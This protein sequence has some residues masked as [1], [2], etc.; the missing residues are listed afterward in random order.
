MAGPEQRGKRGIQGCG[1][2][3]AGLFRQGLA[4]ILEALD[5]QIDRFFKIPQLGGT[6]GQL[7]RELPL[8]LQGFDGLPGS[9][10]VALA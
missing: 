3:I 5:L 7:F 10:V 1:Q 4:G 9:V 8:A 6:L 2:G